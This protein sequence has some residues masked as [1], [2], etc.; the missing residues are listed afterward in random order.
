[1][2]APVWMDPGLGVRGA[3][4]HSRVLRC[5]NVDA[6]VRWRLKRQSA[7]LGWTVR[8]VPF[9]EGAWGVVVYVVACWKNDDTVGV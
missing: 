8:V 1:M 5:G 2:P 7:E 6:H 3:A 4:V 9:L